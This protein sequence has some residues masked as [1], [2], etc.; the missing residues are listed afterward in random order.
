M[1]RLRSDSAGVTLVELAV[2]LVLV[3]I[4]AGIAPQGAGLVQGALGA[5]RAKGAADDIVQAV[6]YARQRAITDAQDYCIALRIVGGV[7]Q[8]E[9]YTGARSGT[10]CA[11]TSVEGP[12]DL[13]GNATI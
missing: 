3:T 4:V 2:V 8:Y 11:G 13:P 1:T 7:G 9:L 12:T 10:A 5:G 6:R